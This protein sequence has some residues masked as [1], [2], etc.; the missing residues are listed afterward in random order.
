MLEQAPSKDLQLHGE[1]RTGEGFLLG[2]VMLWGIQAGVAISLRTAPQEEWPMMSQFS[3]L[4]VRRLTLEKLME[5]CLSCKGPHTR[6]GKGLLSLSSGRM[7][8]D[9]LT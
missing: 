5:N 7:N 6:E 1:T 4:P 2:L 9:E 3:L 8:C